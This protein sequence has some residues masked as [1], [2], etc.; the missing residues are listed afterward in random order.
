MQRMLF[1]YTIYLLSKLWIVEVT[2]SSK[3]ECRYEVAK[4]RI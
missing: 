1:M 3:W 2:G 4:W